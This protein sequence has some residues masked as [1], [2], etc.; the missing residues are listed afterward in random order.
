MKE[1]V[2]A[3]ITT[4]NRLELL[5]QAVESVKNQSYPNIE[6]IIVDDHSTDGTD[7]YCKQLSISTHNITYIYIPRE[8]SKGGNYARNLGI[9]NSHGVYIAFLDDDDIWLPE[10]IN[11]QVQLITDKNCDLV[12]GNR[13]VEVIDPNGKSKFYPSKLNPQYE[14]DVSQAILTDIFTTTSLILVRKSIFELI[15]LF[16]EELKYWQEYELS[17]RIAQLSPFYAVHQP[18]IHYRVNHSDNQRL[19]NKYYGWHKAVKYIHYKHAELYRNLPL[20]L[21]LKSHA[22]VWHDAAERCKASD[23]KIRYIYFHSLWMA[24]KILN[25]VKDGSIFSI[26]KNRIIKILNRNYE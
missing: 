18:L 25:S 9:K 19:T 4:H 8:Q 23:L 15:G 12:Y 21:K 20:Y 22:L 1:L 16:D 24:F 7:E 5:K 11:L 14:G 13:I 2:T 6:L 26:V 17:I 3:I 10:K